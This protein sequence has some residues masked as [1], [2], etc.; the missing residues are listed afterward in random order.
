VAN[1][2][3]VAWRSNLLPA[4][5]FTST[6]SFGRHHL[7]SCIP[8]NVVPVAGED[9]RL[10]SLNHHLRA[11]AIVFDFVNPVLALWR[12][13]DRRSKLWLDEPEPTRCAKHGAALSGFFF[14]L[15]LQLGVSVV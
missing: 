15:R 9:T 3:T 13:I 1:R 11:V 2:F 14:R 8:L 4:K 10:P 6:T 12:L 7:T 5:C